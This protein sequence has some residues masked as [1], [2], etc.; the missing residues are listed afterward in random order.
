MSILLNLQKRFKIT[1]TFER[2]IVLYEHTYITAE[3]LLTSRFKQKWK[4]SH[5]Y[6]KQLSFSEIGVLNSLTIC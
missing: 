3:V 5:S 6:V 2:G 4:Q 1:D